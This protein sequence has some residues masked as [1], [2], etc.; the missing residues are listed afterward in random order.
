MAQKTDNEQQPQHHHPPPHTS[1]TTTVTAVGV[2]TTVPTPLGPSSSVPS[3]PTSATPSSLM[4]YD[5]TVS[6]LGLL[7]SILYR[8]QSILVLN[9]THFD[10]ISLRQLQEDL[11][12]V[13]TAHLTVNQRL[14]LV[15]RIVRSYHFLQPHRKSWPMTG[16]FV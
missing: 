8:L 9:S 16:P 12:D 15:E 14:A 10:N 4:S 11:R 5:L 1:T 6:E 13:T 2:A 3:P 7:L